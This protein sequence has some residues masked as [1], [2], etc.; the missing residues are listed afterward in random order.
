MNQYLTQHNE[1]R[2]QSKM[3]YN[4]RRQKFVK[5][6]QIVGTRIIYELFCELLGI[7]TS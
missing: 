4:K 5:I 3:D 6:M 7:L 2:G 1:I